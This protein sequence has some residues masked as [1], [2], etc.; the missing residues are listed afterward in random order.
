MTSFVVTETE[1]EVVWLFT[2]GALYRL[3]NQTS[4]LILL[5]ISSAAT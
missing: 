2:D 5:L 1:K 4:C 3:D